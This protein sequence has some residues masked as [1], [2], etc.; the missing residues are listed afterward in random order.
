MVAGGTVASVWQESA[1]YGHS[2]ML[3]G[4]AALDDAVVP[5]ENG[6][7]RSIVKCELSSGPS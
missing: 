1:R 5:D 3:N 4:A 6:Y 2:L 7:S